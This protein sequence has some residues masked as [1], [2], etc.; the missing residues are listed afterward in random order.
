LLFDSDFIRL[1]QLRKY[2]E[3]SKRYD[4]LF[5]IPLKKFWNLERASDYNKREIIDLF[6]MSE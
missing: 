1:S 4:P 6:T 2:I 3:F 5:I